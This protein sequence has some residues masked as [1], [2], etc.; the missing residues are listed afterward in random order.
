MLASNGCRQTGAPR[1]DAGPVRHYPISGRV[2]GENLASGEIELDAAAIPGFMDAM[3]MPYRVADAAV[4]KQVH[5]GDR[6]SGVLDVT[7]DGTTLDQVRI[8]DSSKEVRDP[9]PQSLMK[10]L[11]PGEAVPDFAFL[12][13]DAKTVHLSDFHGKLLLVTFVYTHCPLSDYCP[14][15]SR[16]FAEIDKSLAATGPLYAATHL[17]TVS[18]DPARDTPAALRSYGGAYTG[19]YVNETFA[20]WTFAAPPEAELAR[21]LDFFDVGSVPAPGGTLT[22]TLSTVEIGPDGRI[23]KWYGGNDWTSAAVLADVKRALQ[24]ATAGSAA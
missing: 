22:H 5:Q 17:L 11:V 19:N 15:M 7:G 14:R 23:L 3:T 21:V 16:N 8:T 12:D 13:Q 18:F 4:L 24:P 1:A 2:V 10:P 9:V 20:H 6:I